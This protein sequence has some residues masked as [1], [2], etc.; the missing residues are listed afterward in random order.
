[1]HVYSYVCVYVYVPV[2]WRKCKRLG[3]P[4]LHVS[5]AL[6]KSA[7][8]DLQKFLVEEFLGWRIVRG[9]A[10]LHVKW[11]GYQETTW[12]SLKAL[13]EDVPFL[14]RK[15]VESLAKARLTR[16]YDRIVAAAQE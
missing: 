14:V 7:L 16:A 9:Q 8:H 3:G 15:Y 6:R 4:E 5:E 13:H 10:Q 1:M 2:S 11:R 12:Q